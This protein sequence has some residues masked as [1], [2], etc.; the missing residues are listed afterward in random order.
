MNGMSDATLDLERD[1]FALVPGVL[2]PDD[3]EQAL[4]DCSAALARADP[5]VLSGGGST[6]GAR[7]LLRLWPGVV[8]L[9]RAP[10]LRGLLRDALGPGAGVVRGLY[11]D[12]PPGQSWALPWHRDLTVAVAK[13]RPAAGFSKPTTK[14][15]V[16]HLEAPPDL[17]ATMLTL[18]FHLDAMTPNNGPLRLTR[19]SHVLG[20]ETRGEYVLECEAGDVLLMRPLTLH[21][22]GHA[23]PGWRGHRRVVH[24]ELAPSPTL[25]EGL[26]WREFGPLS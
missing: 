13:H 2:S 26:E 1:G 6:Y 23:A 10:A 4:G 16:P 20:A 11:F 24:L 14:A 7:D 19:G 12:K 17:L 8:D 25:A 21:A 15:G 5:G 18:R 9:A 3:V 22:S